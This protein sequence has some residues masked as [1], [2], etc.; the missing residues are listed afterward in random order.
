[1]MARVLRLSLTEMKKIGQI[2]LIAAVP[3][4]ILAVSIFLSSKEE[5]SACNP[6]GSSISAGAPSAPS[7][8]YAEKRD[9]AVIIFWAPNPESDIKGYYIYRARN[10]GSNPEK[11][12]TAYRRDPDPYQY[13]FRYEDPSAE[14]GFLYMVLAIDSD[15]NESPE[16]RAVK[17][18]ESE[19]STVPPS[20]K[21]EG[22]TDLPI[23][24]VIQNT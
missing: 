4:V 17:A 11:I 22:N 10:T 24:P 3:A 1:M 7:E 14:D 9:G 15:N 20:V 5:V 8:V 19:R 6:V 13:F 23:E 21:R 12:G 2:R 18:R 16:S